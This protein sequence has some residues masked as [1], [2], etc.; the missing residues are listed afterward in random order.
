MHS[1]MNSKFAIGVLVVIILIVIGTLVGVGIYL[2]NQP[3]EDTS[4]PADDTDEN[5][6]TDSPKSA[7]P[8]QDQPETG[9]STTSPP[10]DSASGA[11]NTQPP[12]NA[13]NDAS[14]SGTVAPATDNIE[15]LIADR[16]LQPGKISTDVQ[17]L[18][19]AYN[20]NDTLT[21]GVNPSIQGYDTVPLIYSFNGITNYDASYRNK[22]LIWIS[23]RIERAMSM[24]TILKR[25][26]LMTDKSLYGTTPTMNCYGFY[27]KSHEDGKTYTVVHIPKYGRIGWATGLKGVYVDN[28]D[29]TLTGAI[30]DVVNDSMASTRI[31]F[32]DLKLYRA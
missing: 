11:T 3:A 29:G 25:V 13:T 15:F 28:I 2:N 10:S 30:M 14:G 12:A 22:Q 32:N 4:Q 23:I 9:N 5:T 8:K 6:S 26:Y 27:G 31:V 21:E 7:A 1:V 24:I 19:S 20:M 17:D 18:K 16:N